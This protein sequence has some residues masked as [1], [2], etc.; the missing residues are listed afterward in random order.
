MDEKEYNKYSIET[1]IS[2]IVKFMRNNEYCSCG[3]RNIFTIKSGCFLDQNIM[4][5]KDLKCTKRI[6]GKFQ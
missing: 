1:M 6:K 5:T 3:H 4:T 2:Q